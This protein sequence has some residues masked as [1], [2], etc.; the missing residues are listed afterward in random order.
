MVTRFTAAAAQ[1]LKLSA[2]ASDVVSLR[3]RD[4]HQQLYPVAG[5]F[6]IGWIFGIFAASEKGSKIPPENGARDAGRDQK[7]GD[8]QLHYAEVGGVACDKPAHHNSRYNQY[9]SSQPIE[10]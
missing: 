9:P 6:A 8:G 7:E 3:T 4:G 1:L 5:L 10:H 2:L